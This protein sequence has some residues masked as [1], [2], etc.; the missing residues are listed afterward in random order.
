[1][2]S[3]NEDTTIYSVVL[4]GELMTHVDWTNTTGL[5]Y[6]KNAGAYDSVK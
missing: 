1:M 2:W 4:D 6:T 3:L 5:R